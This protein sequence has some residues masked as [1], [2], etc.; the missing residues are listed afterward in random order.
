MSNEII[1]TGDSDL[2][3]TE[4]QAVEVVKKKRKGK[5]PNW[6]MYIE[7]GDNARYLRH[8][9][10]TYNLPP[11]DISDEK[12]VEERINWYFGHCINAD[13]KPTVQGLCN[14]IGISRN[15]LNEWVNGVTRDLTHGDIAKKAYTILRELYEDYMLNG[16]INPVA[17]IFIGKNHFGYTD[18]TEVVLTPNRPLGDEKTPEDIIKALPED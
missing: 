13:M 17:G 7:P 6:E 18:K 9:L 15:T 14:A 10:A 4:E 2:S 16:K 3:L 5:N 11:I 12:Q 1:K 8:A